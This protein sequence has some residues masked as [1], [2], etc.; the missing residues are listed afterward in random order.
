MNPLFAAG[1]AAIL[2]VSLTPAAQAGSIETAE[3]HF[4]SGKKLFESGKHSEALDLYIKAYTTYPD[5]KYVFGIASC[6]VKLGNLPRALDAYE[7]YTQYDPTP[8]ILTRVEK[9]TRQLKEM[10]AKEYAE[11]FIFSSPPGAQIIIGDFS[12]HNVYTTPKRRWLKE[13]S[14]SVFFKKDK[15][16]PREMKL[17]VKKGEHLYIYAG[18][19][20][21]K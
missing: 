16:A 17:S 14:H 11:V 4:S 6:H 21:E 15:H 12:K 18:L 13:G 3:Q 7:E 8:Q 9:E 10:L 20:P 19:K 5:S 1:I 2:L